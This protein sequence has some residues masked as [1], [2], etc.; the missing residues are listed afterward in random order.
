MVS[1]M[2]LFIV[3]KDILPSYIVN[4]LLLENKGLLMYAGE[5]ELSKR[6]N[7]TAAALMKDHPNEHSLR[8]R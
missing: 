4:M 3:H 1:D 2:N 8:A 7:R 6:L 5:I